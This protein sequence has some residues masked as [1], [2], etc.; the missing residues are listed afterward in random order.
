MSVNNQEKLTLL[1]I[2]WPRRGYLLALALSMAVGAGVV[3]D[4]LLLLNGIPSDSR[5]NFRLMAQAWDLIDHFYVDR[6]ADRH[7]AMTYGAINGMVDALGDTN[8]SIFLSRSQAKLAGTTVQGKLVGIGI[9]FS[10]IARGQQ[11]RKAGNGA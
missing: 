6:S 7:M 8:H 9:Q 1:S 5:E 11:L 4:R 10:A 3:M 2:R